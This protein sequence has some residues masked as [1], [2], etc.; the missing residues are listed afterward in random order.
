[1]RRLQI[2]KERKNYGLKIGDSH[3]KEEDTPMLDLVGGQ[4]EVGAIQKKGSR[5]E[6]ADKKR[7]TS[8][9]TMTANQN[10]GKEARDAR[11]GSKTLAP[12]MEAKDSKRMLAATQ[13][14]KCKQ[15]EAASKPLKKPIKTKLD[16][17]YLQSAQ[18]KFCQPENITKDTLDTPAAVKKRRVEGEPSAQLLHNSE[19]AK[20]DQ[21]E[22]RRKLEEIRKGAAERNARK[23]GQVR[24]SANSARNAGH[25][26]GSA[27]SVGNQGQ[28]N[29][30]QVTDQRIQE[31]DHETTSTN[32]ES[33][34]QDEAEIM[35]QDGRKKGKRVPK[36][37]ATTVDDFL[38]EN[39]IDVE[40]V[41]ANFGIDVDGPGTEPTF[42]V[43]DSSALHAD[44]YHQVMA[45]IDDKQGEPKK[46]R[47]RGKTKCAKIY[48][49]LMH[50][51]FLNVQK[52]SCGNMLTPSCEKWVIQTARDAWKRFKGK[53]KC[54][55][56]VPYDNLEDMFKNRPLQVA[57]CQ[58]IKLFLYWS[59][60][61]VQVLS[62]TNK[63]HK[64]Q[65]K[66]P[67]RMGPIN[68]ERVRAAMRAANGKNEEPKRF[69]MFIVTRTSQKTKEF[70]EGTQSVIQ[71]FQSRQASGETEEEAFKSVFG[72][73]QP[74]RV[75]CYG[76]AI[77]QSD[78]KRHAEISAIKEQ[79]EEEVQSLKGELGDVKE[80]VHGL[81][82]MVKLLLQGSEPGMTPEEIEA[83]LK[84][85]QHS[86]VD[87][88]SGHGSTHP[89]NINMD[90]IG[91]DNEDQE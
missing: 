59:H 50:E 51:L 1:M 7:K 91:E 66:F 15:S 39:G 83:M 52:L 22:I 28:E 87:A 4:K 57:K 9:Q 29:N 5:D 46:T 70:D 10:D 36:L 81:R 82:A 71:D 73:E 20:K 27:N 34:S 3:D 16:F 24:S 77:T 79:H 37:R 56:F 19:L 18:Q 80:E 25:E 61:T 30:M 75:R 84:N 33:T 85:P 38:K 32:S 90:N 14:N 62:N 88:N 86:P 54:R 21:T 44:Y 43:N 45:D 12:T 8:M 69:Q 26:Q 65:Q 2:V 17:S 13:I 31:R 67:H 40:N 48:G 58:F 11:K 89:P 63:Q 74:G 23:A 76:R 60:P 35:V 6:A 47:T 68:F 41:L 64:S 72:K 55:H 53:I 49:R 78:L 42:D